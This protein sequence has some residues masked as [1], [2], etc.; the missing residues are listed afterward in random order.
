MITKKQ[1]CE[2]ILAEFCRSENILQENIEEHLTKSSSVC[3][4]AEYL[5]LIKEPYLQH[6]T[7]SRGGCQIYICG[8]EPAILTTRELLNLLPE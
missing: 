6:Y 7:K 4:A 3:V 1:L 5:G 2:H 8:E